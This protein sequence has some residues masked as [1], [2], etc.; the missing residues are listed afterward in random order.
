MHTVSR[1]GMSLLSS[2]PVLYAY[3]NMHTSYSLTHSHADTDAQAQAQLYIH[4]NI[5]YQR[6]Q[7]YVHTHA[8]T[9][10]QAFMHIYSRVLLTYMHLCASTK[11]YTRIQTK[12]DSQ[13]LHTT[14]I[15]TQIHS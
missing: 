12:N 7:A 11:T 6:T 1:Q 5:L 2:V 9:R 13:T 14:H 4:Q 15:H 3:M 10:T 8:Y